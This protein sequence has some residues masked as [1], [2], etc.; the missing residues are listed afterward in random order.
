MLAWLRLGLRPPSRHQW[1]LRT[2]SPII[3]FAMHSDKLPRSECAVLSR[4]CPRISVLR[5]APV[6][7]WALAVFICVFGVVIANCAIFSLFFF[8]VAS[9]LSLRRARP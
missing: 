3:Q 6:G 9:R 8:P 1:K 5:A 2:Y 7:S 4:G